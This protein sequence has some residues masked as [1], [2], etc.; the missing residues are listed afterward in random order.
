MRLAH[1]VTDT[2]V[3]PLND[4]FLDLDV[5]A[6]I[7]PVTFAVTGVSHYA[8][9]VREMRRHRRSVDGD[10]TDWVVV[11]NRISPGSSTKPVL[12]DCKNWRSRWA[13]GSRPASMNVRSIAIFS[14]AGSPRWIPFATL[15]PPPIRSVPF[16]IARREIHALLEV[17]KLPI[18]DRGRRR[19][20]ARAEW[21]AARTQPLDTGDILAELPR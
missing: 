18:D 2:L 14:R 13:F 8:E 6:K 15:C 19:A 9:L 12:C 4:S 16:P 5:L 3:T 1:S 11:R 17:L 7:D 21:F 20:A 10:L